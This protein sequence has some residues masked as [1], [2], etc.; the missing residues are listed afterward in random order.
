M[1]DA[2]MTDLS[3]SMTKQ[4]IILQGMTTVTRINGRML[5]SGEFNGEVAIVGKFLGDD[6]NDSSLP[7]EASDGEKFTV[8][9]DSTQPWSG[10]KSKYVEIRG[11]V[12]DD[13]TIL[14]D[15]YQEFGNDFAMET[16]DK[17]LTLAQQYPAIF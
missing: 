17:F 13:G 4:A 1:N 6:T 11:Q 15:T 12:Q 5:K 14:Q 9:R 2:E 7:F 16:W 8:K 10:Y 3:Q